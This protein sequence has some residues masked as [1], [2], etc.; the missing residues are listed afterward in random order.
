L[1]NETATSGVYEAWAM[2]T[3][4]T[5]SVSRYAMNVLP[6]EGD[7]QVTP[8]NVLTDN[9]A[10]AK[11]EFSYWGEYEATAVDQAG[12]NWSYLLLALLVLFLLLEQLLAYSAS[13]HPPRGAAP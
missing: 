11:P 3:G 7:L 8:P 10:A 6:A 13:Y 9:L 5:P 1:E 4:G 12:F 2:S